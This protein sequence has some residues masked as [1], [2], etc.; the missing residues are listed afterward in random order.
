MKFYD[1]NSRVSPE[2]MWAVCLLGLRSELS[3][4]APSG[5]LFLIRDE[6]RPDWFTLG[7]LGISYL[8]VNWQIYYSLRIFSLM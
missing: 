7:F 3:G 8:S 5:Y 1:L 2:T 4:D 6:L